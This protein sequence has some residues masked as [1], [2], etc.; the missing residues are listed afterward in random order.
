MSEQNQNPNDNT[1]TSANPEK[2]HRRQWNIN[3]EIFCQVYQKSNSARE[4]AE[5]LGV[6]VQVVNSRASSLRRRGVSL[7]SFIGARKKVDVTSLNNII[8]EMK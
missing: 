2:R 7:K 1:A 8:N 4:V 3:N 6:S 5:S